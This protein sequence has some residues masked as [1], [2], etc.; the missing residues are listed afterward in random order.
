MEKKFRLP[1]DIG[2]KWLIALRSGEYKQG[3]TVLVRDVPGYGKKY[4]CIGVLG[5][6]CGV[7]FKIM[8]DRGLFDSGYI[9]NMILNG[10]PIPAEIKGNGESNA[11]VKELI[12]RN[13]GA[14]KFQNNKQSFEQIADFIEAEVEFY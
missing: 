2:E 4:C 5:D 10:L 7:S 9:A 6:I 8:D 13:D 11:L 1:K 14:D 12:Y 3:Q